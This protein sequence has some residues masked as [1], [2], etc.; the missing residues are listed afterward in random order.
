MVNK[1]EITTNRPSTSQLVQVSSGE[2][3]TADTENANNLLTLQ[4]L[5]L[6]YNWVIDSG[7]ELSGT[8]IYTAIQQ[9]A[10][11][12]KAGQIDPLTV[13][14]NMILNVGTGKVYKNSVVPGNDFP[15][16]T[17]V[18]TLISS[19]VGANIDLIYGGIRTSAFNAVVNTLYLIN[20]TSSAFAGTLPSTATTGDV[21]GF[22]DIKGKWNTNNFTVGGN[23]RNIMDLAEDLIGNVQY[24][25][26][27]LIYDTTNGW[28]LV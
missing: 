25:K 18:N 27:Y 14:G 17:E 3:V 20:T 9:F 5:I 19:L 28:Y 22:I 8:N 4:A 12:L 26:I 6:A 11:G 21:I 16:A 24:G 23:T 10:A 15:T 1:A 7:V 2:I 13:N